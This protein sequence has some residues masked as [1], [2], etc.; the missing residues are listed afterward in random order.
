MSDAALEE[1]SV[2]S[3]IYCGKDEFDLLEHGSNEKELV[4][5]IQVAVETERGKI[6][7][8][9]VFSLPPEYPHCLPDVSVTSQQLTRT[10]CQLVRQG[11][12]EKAVEFCSEPMVHKLLLWL[13]QN[14]A[15]I[16]GIEQRLGAVVDPTTATDRELWMAL[17]LLDHM[18]AKTKY[19][20]L[21]EKWT[22]ELELTG[23]LFTGPLILIILQGA[24]RNIKEYLHLQKTVKVD[25]DTAGK[26]CKEKMMRILCEVPL[27]EDFKEMTSFEVK[28]ISFVEELKR[29]FELVGLL[30]LYQDFVCSLL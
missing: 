9:L 10:Q 5:Q 3:A 26:K 19:R 11:L 13:Q 12:L 25:V 24:K 29:E 2:L 21:I 1:I 7:L 8:R 30:E 18:R 28:D 27:P 4:F 15:G 20:K 23:R 14:L 17:L 6:K 22:S 16:A